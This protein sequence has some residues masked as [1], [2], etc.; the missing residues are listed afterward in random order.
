MQA[1]S[2]LTHLTNSLGPSQAP[3]TMQHSA[4]NKYNVALALENRTCPR[5]QMSRVPSRINYGLR[6]R[7]KPETRVRVDPYGII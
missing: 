1:S 2:S 4:M 5:R 7:H 6:L 3:N